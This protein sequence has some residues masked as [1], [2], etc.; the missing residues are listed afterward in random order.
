[1]DSLR[2]QSQRAQKSL[3]TGLEQEYNLRFKKWKKEKT[4]LLKE[5]TIKGLEPQLNNMIKKHEN[6]KVRDQN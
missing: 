1:M 4:T 2:E 3:R 6:E 5:M